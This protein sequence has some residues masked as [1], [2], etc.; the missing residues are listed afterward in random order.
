MIR[1][2]VSILLVL[3]AAVEA[4]AQSQDVEMADLLRSNGKIYVVVGVLLIIFIGLF[5]YLFSL[6]RKIR[7]LEEEVEN[8]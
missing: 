3:G 2:F 4:F 7:K 8:R 1:K 6:D 5:L